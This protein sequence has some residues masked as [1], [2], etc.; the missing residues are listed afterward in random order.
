VKLTVG[1]GVQVQ[2]G[3]AGATVQ[4]PGVNVK[5]DEKTGEVKINLGAGGLKVEVQGEGTK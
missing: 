1:G 5:T 3:E 2:T 4:A